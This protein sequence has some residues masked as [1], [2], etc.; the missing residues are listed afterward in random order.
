LSESSRW[1][2]RS[3]TWQTVVFFGLFYPYYSRSMEKRSC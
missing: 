3:F 2:K 1:P